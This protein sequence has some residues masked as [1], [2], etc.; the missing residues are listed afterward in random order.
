LVEID[1]PI[2]MTEF[3]A[4][5]GEGLY[6]ELMKKGVVVC[7]N[8]SKRRV[9]YLR[10]IAEGM[11]YISETVSTGVQTEPHEGHWKYQYIAQMIKKRRIS[12]SNAIMLWDTW[13]GSSANISRVIE[14]SSND[15]GDTLSLYL[16]LWHS[17]RSKY[18]I[19][20]IL[21]AMFGGYVEYSPFRQYLGMEIETYTKRIRLLGFYLPKKLNNIRSRVQLTDVHMS[22]Q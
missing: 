11:P 2:K 16:S 7:N 3:L 4:R 15:T 12:E 1:P 5:Q 21:T 13:I 20:D 18:E 10:L 6:K 22:F 17:K 9:L 14:K 19:Q 8:G